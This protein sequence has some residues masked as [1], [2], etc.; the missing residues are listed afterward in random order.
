MKI[1]LLR[2]SPQDDDTLGLLFIDAKFACYTLE[3]EPREVKVP[4]E[5]CIPVGTYRIDLRTDGLMTRRYAKKFPDMHRGMLHLQDVPGFEYVYI[6]YGNHEGQT[7]GCIL[8]GDT[9]QQ[10]V[11]ERGFVGAAVAAYRRIYQPICDA[12]MVGEKVSITV[13]NLE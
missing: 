8:V 7:D 2:Y 6:H 3:D 13:E 12:I 10:N 1:H 11:T 9:A 4:G 5:T